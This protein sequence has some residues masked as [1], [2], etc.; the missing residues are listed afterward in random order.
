MEIVRDAFAAFERGDVTKL[1]D[2]MAD[3]LVTHRIDPDNAVYHGKV[4]FFEATAEWIEDFEDWTVT[5]EEF[6]GASDGVVVRVRQTA[7]GRTSG[8]PVESLMWFG[9]RIDGG[10][11]TRLTFHSDEAQAFEAAELS[12]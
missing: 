5:P 10:R 3:D 12:E 8:V 7:R 2:L 4:G 9:L 1:L 6:F 11:I